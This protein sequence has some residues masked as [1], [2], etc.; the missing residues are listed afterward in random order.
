MGKKGKRGR[1]LPSVVSPSRGGQLLLCY[2]RAKGLS[3]SEFAKKLKVHRSTLLRAIRANPKTQ[4]AK[5]VYAV[6]EIL[7]HIVYPKDWLEKRMDPE[8]AKN[9]VKERIEKAD[10]A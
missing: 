7:T 2:L 9:L 6:D 8:G 4:S 10:S 5:F 1:P 3:A